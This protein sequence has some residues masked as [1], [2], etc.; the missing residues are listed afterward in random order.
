M[1]LLEKSHHIYQQ[2]DKSNSK[3]IIIG[4]EIKFRGK[5]KKQDIKE[6]NK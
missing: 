4:I 3:L 6:P 1:N 5:F 2:K